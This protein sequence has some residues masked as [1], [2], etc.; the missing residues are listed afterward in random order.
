MDNA[1]AKKI[2]YNA[3]ITYIAIMVALYITKPNIIYNHK[4]KKFKSFGFGD[5]NSVFS[6]PIT[7]TIMSIVVY[8]IFVV[9]SL[10]AS[11][12]K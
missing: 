4:S 3:I 5:D 9:Y 1:T 6:L 8:I 7:G 11:K 10:L 12:L 2:L